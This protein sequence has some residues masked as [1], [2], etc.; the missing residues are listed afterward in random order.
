M[1]SYPKIPR[2][3]R[4]QLLALISGI[5]VPARKRGDTLLSDPQ[6]DAASYRLRVGVRATVDSWCGA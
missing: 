2:A 1:N 4:R 3:Q 5:V 6:R